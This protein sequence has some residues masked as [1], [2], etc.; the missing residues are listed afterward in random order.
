RHNTHEDYLQFDIA[1]YDFGLVAVDDDSANTRFNIQYFGSDFINDCKPPYIDGENSNYFR[2]YS[3]NCKEVFTTN[4][5]S[6]FVEVQA[7][8]RSNMEDLGI[9]EHTAN[10]VVECGADDNLYQITAEITAIGY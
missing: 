7:I 9:G 3:T 6:C 4:N 10:L 8:P 1:S 2:V 5:S